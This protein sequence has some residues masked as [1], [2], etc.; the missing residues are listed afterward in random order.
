[1]TRFE[2]PEHRAVNETKFYFQ[3][4]RKIPWGTLWA[5]IHDTWLFVA[6]DEYMNE[7]VRQ[8]SEWAN[9]K[10][11]NFVSWDVV[12]DGVWHKMMVAMCNKSHSF[13]HQGGLGLN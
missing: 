5:V 11:Q 1:M 3:Q 2:S 9:R 12:S 4:L 8:R 6:L 10:P 13:Y 7:G